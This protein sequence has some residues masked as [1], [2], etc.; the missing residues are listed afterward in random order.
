MA[1]QKLKLDGVTVRLSGGATPVILECGIGTLEIDLGEFPIEEIK[2]WEGTKYMKG[3]VKYAPTKIE[4]YFDSKGNDAGQQM[5]LDALYD[6]DQFSSDSNMKME[7]EFDDGDGG[8]IT[9]TTISFYALVTKGTVTVEG[10]TNLKL[11]FDIQQT[12]KPVIDYSHV[13]I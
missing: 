2:C 10:G 1:V 8:A 3:G 9:N 13:S 4:G 7:I 11:D 5:L 6:E 12:T